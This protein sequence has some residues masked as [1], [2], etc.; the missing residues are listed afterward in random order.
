MLSQAEMEHAQRKLLGIN[1]NVRGKEF[2]ENVSLKET[3]TVNS[4]DQ[5][6]LKILNQLGGGEHLQVGGA[7]YGPQPR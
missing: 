5:H 7:D 6:R 1:D 4:Q 2:S 3:M